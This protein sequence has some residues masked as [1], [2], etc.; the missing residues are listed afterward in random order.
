MKAKIIPIITIISLFS[1]IFYSCED[2]TYKEYKGNA[3]V[4]ISYEDLRSSVA[5]ELNVDL[6][7]PGKIYYKDNY[8]F[9]I[10]ELKGIHVY[11]NNDP[12]APV[13][14]SFIKVPG[15][16]DMAILGNTLYADSFVD[17][18]VLDIQ[19]VDNIHEVG[20]VLDI[21][22]YTVPPTGNEF[23]KAYVDQS[24]GLVV[25]WELKTI[26][27]RVYNNPIV[28]PVFNTYRNKADGAYYSL[29][30]SAG[31]S[32][33]GTG[34]GGSM[35]RFGIK[36]KMLYL[37]DGSSLKLFDITAKSTPNKLFDIY[38]GGGIETMFLSGNYMFLGTTTGMI[39]YDITNSQSPLWKSSYN[40]IRSCDPVVVDD[41]LAYITLRSGTNCGSA[42]NC[43]DVINIKNTLQPSLV[44]SYSMTNPYGLGKNGDLL[45]VCDGTAGLKVYNASDPLNITG[46][47][48]FAYPG[49]K[50]YDV[51]PVGDILVLIGDDG[52]YQYNYS[53]IQNITLLS[54]I[55][56]VK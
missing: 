43:L 32:G 47:L 39:I 50:A 12:S 9:I 34:I 49:I 37:L 30:A 14:K 8:I 2:S 11:D 10:E 41:T 27:E 17:L 36:D 53:N 44:K 28:Y 26:R 3:P 25:S 54:T 33:S 18:V 40:H 20:R 24:K 31:V 21:L 52:L 29:S 16:V 13:K 19:D 42:V 51:V 23:P 55:S 38:M 56:V 5:E 46:N 35:A 6:K 22:P 15:V 45:F 7:N 4:Y 48:I 1:V